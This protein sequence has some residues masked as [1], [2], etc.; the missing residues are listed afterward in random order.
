MRSHC[1]EIP[2]CHHTVCAE[3]RERI[4]RAYKDGGDIVAV[5]LQLSIRRTTAWSIVVLLIHLHL[6]IWDIIAYAHC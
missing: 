1:V 5:A 2:Q 6:P 4:V 3:D